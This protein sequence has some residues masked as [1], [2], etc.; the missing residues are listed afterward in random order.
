MIR[1]T[2]AVALLLMLAASAAAQSVPTLTL[3]D[4]IAL[5]LEQSGT[6]QSARLAAER[7]RGD[8]ATART[9]RL[10]AFNTETQVSRLLRPVNVTFPAGAFGVFPPIGPVPAEDDDRD[11]AGADHACCSVPASRNRSRVFSTPAWASVKAKPR[12]T[13]PMKTRVRHD[14]AWCAT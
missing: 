9:R 3:D 11:N 4:A 14:L 13:W 5:A 1:A 7:A 12:G 2:V 8:V 10:P 6:V